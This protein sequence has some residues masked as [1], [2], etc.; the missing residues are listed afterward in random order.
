[1][2][3]PRDWFDIPGFNGAYQAS[4]DGYIHTIAT[5]LV[6]KGHRSGNGYLTV[7]LHRKTYSVHSLIA[8]T[9]L[10]ERP[11]G[12]EVCHRNGDRRDNRIGNLYYG[13]R[14]DNMKDAVKHGTHKSGVGMRK[15]Y[16][17]KGLHSLADPDN[18]SISNGSRRCRPCYNKWQ[19]DK[20][21][22][23]N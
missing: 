20:R 10:G 11:E 4:R 7:S 21:N 9:F 17:L 23:S 19:R 12:K 6:R 22:G 13:T 1:M 3:T 8:I 2:T 16:C 18:V 5:G 15:E 14:S